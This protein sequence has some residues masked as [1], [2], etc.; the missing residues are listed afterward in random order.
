M[1]VGYRLSAV[2]SLAML[3]NIAS[4]QHLGLGGFI[5]KRGRG[6]EDA[7]PFFM[8]IRVY[9]YTGIQVYR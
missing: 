2:N 4:C 8:R 3:G 1:A 5:G 7:K 6:V 9:A